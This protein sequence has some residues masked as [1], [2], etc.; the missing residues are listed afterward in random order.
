M[1]RCCSTGVLTEMRG[2]AQGIHQTGW[3]GLVAQ[4]IA[5]QRFASTERI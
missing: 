3:P 4:I 2:L 1:A 5:Q